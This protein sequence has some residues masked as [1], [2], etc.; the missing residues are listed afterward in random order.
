MESWLTDVPRMRIPRPKFAGG[1][2]CPAE[3][4]K[5][6]GDEDSA[7]GKRDLGKATEELRRAIQDKL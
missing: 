6:Y 4:P 1:S 3:P 2:R 7:K 5:D